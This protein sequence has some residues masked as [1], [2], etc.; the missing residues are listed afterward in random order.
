MIKKIR[1]TRGF[2]IVELLIATTV[3]TVVLVGA[4]FV[5]VQVGRLYYKGTITARTQSAGRN[6][7]DSISRPIQ[8][9][10]S[11]VRKAAIGPVNVLCVGNQRFT[12]QTQAQVGIGGS[13][14]PHA[15]WRDTINNLEACTSSVPDI[16]NTGI[17]LTGG[18][19]MLSDGMRLF[20]LDVVETIDGSGTDT[21][22]YLV[23]VRMGYGE[24]DTF[25]TD[26]LSGRQDGCLGQTAGGQFCA[27]AAYETTVNARIRQ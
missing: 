7:V 15:V 12:Y 24:L 1:E 25:S 3:L 16:L 13:R 11:G 18:D 14:R 27:Y 6:I 10:G 4:S 23:T 26:P 19:S 9:R 22:I 20:E 21:G 17:T 5:L 2:T 8:L